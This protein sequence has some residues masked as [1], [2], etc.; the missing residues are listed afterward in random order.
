MPGLAGSR[1]AFQLSPGL[2]D[3]PSRALCGIETGPFSPGG[4]STSPHPESLPSPC[5]KTSRHARGGSALVPL[6][7]AGRSRHPRVR[8]LGPPKDTCPPGR[9]AQMPVPNRAIR[10][11]VAA[12]SHGWLTPNWRR[13]SPLGP[14]ASRINVNCIRLMKA[15]RVDFGLQD[16][17]GPRRARTSC[18]S[19]KT[20]RCSQSPVGAGTSCSSPESVRL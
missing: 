17:Y 1:D 5:W 7:S 6:S 9:C 3:A 19:S 12:Y 8:T 4:L 16:R 15:A 10:L 2:G 20:M 14:A 18:R 11:A 13:T